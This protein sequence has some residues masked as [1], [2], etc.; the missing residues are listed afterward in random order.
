MR[1]VNFYTSVSDAGDAEPPFVDI[2]SPKISWLEVIVRIEVYIRPAKRSRRVAQKDIIV[3]RYEHNVDGIARD[4]APALT[5]FEIPVS[6]DRQKAVDFT[7]DYPTYSGAGGF[8][9]LTGRGFRV[10]LSG[11]DR[12]SDFQ[13]ISIAVERL[14]QDDLG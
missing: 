4:V 3:E 5:S 8:P 12:A 14:T 1:P 13:R 9:D 10:R 6:F 2:P 11:K 7:K